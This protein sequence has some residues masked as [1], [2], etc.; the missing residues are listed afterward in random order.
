M[1]VYFLHDSE[2]KEILGIVTIIKEEIKVSK[3]ITELKEGWEDFNKLEEHDLNSKSVYD[4]VIWFNE[5]YITQIVEVD[6]DYIQP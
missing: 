5:N 2:T 3:G 6:V 1:K 4:F